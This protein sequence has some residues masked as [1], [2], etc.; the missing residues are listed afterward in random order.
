MEIESSLRN[1]VFWN[2]N[3]TLFQ[4]KAGRWIMSRNVIFVL[5]YHRHKLLEDNNIS[6]L[7]RAWWVCELL[8]TV[9]SPAV[10]SGGWHCIEV[11][12]RCRPLRIRSGLQ[13][14]MDSLT[15]CFS[16]SGTRPAG[17][18]GRSAG[19]NNQFTHTKSNYRK[20]NKICVQKTSFSLMFYYDSI[21]GNKTIIILCK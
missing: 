19:L 20:N 8:L 7:R 10:K 5:T 17:G 16:T 4:I 12:Y 21:T 13:T 11:W 18:P 6:Y 3:R 15:N 9:P 1:V 2:I 14:R